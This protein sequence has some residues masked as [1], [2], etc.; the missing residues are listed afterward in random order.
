MTKLER[1]KFLL[2][3]NKK[4]EEEKKKQ[5][6]EAEEEEERAKD[7]GESVPTPSKRDNG[8]G[9]EEIVIAENSEG[10]NKESGLEKET[11]AGA[12][13]QTRDSRQ[14]QGSKK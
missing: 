12:Q 6:E 14:S 5:K 11:K 9:H 8:V 1:V 13:K 7:F 4:E 10:Q 3:W 2:N